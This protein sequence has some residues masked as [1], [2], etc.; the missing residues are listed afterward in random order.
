[1]SFAT[2]ADYLEALRNHRPWYATT[3]LYVGTL[4]LAL[5]LGFTMV[6]TLHPHP[7]AAN[8]LFFGTVLLLPAGWVWMDAAHRVAGK[9]IRRDWNS[10]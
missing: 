6:F 9:R 5:V 10:D 3:A 1:M 4:V 2:R 7:V 8:L